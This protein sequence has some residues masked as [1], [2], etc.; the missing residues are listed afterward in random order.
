MARVVITSGLGVLW[1][2]FD[3][4]S[5]QMHPDSSRVWGGPKT[6]SGHCWSKS[7]TY[8]TR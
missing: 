1:S 4:I 5:E 3:D 8:F 6:P 2:N 7:P